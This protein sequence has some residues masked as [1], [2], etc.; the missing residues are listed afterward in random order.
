MIPLSAQTNQAVAM[1]S[2]MAEACALD[3][4]AKVP[5]LA[6]AASIGTQAAKLILDQLEQ[7]DLVIEGFDAG[8]YRLTKDPAAMTMFDVAVVFE[9]PLQNNL[10]G[11]ARAMRPTIEEY[12]RS[13]TFAACASGCPT[14][15][16]KAEDEA[17][18]PRSRLTADDTSAVQ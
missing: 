1:L 8:G 6:A 10:A 5:D 11:I 17:N 3:I 9:K 18:C 7:A 4:E 2:K 15:T 16:D 12:F 13:I 14:E